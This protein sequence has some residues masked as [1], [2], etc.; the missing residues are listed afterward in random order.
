MVDA[1]RF[2]SQMPELHVKNRVLANRHEVG[3]ALRPCHQ[4][5]HSEHPTEWVELYNTT[6]DRLDIGGMWIDDRIGG[7]GP[8][9][10]PPGTILE[11]S[12]YHVMDFTRFLNNGG[13]DVRLLG[14][15]GAAVHD[16][17]TYTSSERNRSYCRTPDGNDWSGSYCPPTKGAAN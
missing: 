2:P 12:G 6:S 13:D 15:N 9:L 17:Y 11:P 4:V 10:I 5:D 14:T 16:S 3:R 7:K 8:K 1:H